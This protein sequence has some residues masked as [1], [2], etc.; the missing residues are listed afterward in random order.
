MKII[1]TAGAVGVCMLCMTFLSITPVIAQQNPKLSDPEVASVAVTANQID[2]S[3]AEIAKKKSKDAEVLK[4]AETMARDHKAV[5]EQAAALVKKLGVTPKDNAVSQKLL[6]DAEKTKKSLRAKSGKAFNKAYIDN[7]VAYHKAVIN[8][9]ENL[10]IP[11]TDNAELKTLLQNVLP[12]LKAHL[13]HA[14]MIQKTM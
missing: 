5:I 4:F 3:Y 10:L 13:G 12:A 7:E 8:A 9:V 2:I 14:E 6:A 11:E 1:K